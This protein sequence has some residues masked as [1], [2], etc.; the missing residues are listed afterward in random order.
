MARSFGVD[1]SRMQGAVSRLNHFIQVARKADAMIIWTKGIIATDRSM[2]NYRLQWGE[3]KNIKV[4]RYD[5]EGIEFYSEITPP[6]SNEYVI[7]KWDYDAFENTDLD[8]LLRCNSIRTLLLTGF[9]TNVCVESTARHGFTKGY[10]VV[11]ISD[12]TDAYTQH[13][14]DA[15]VFNIKTYFG[16]VSSSEKIIK[17]WE[18]NVT[19]YLGVI[20]NDQK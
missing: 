4:V 13:E 15:T 18:S 7:T 9:A 16:K 12:C 2:P 10:Y 5:T 19:K 14:Y 6:L 3:G 1:V 17:V 11:L 8:L 20:E